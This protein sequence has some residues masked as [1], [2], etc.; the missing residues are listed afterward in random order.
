MK[1]DWLGSPAETLQTQWAT[2]KKQANSLMNSGCERNRAG[3]GEW[4]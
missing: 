4:R 3:G 1:F 2:F